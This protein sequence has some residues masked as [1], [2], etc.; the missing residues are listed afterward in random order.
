M[1]LKKLSFM[2]LRFPANGTTGE[3]NNMTVAERKQMAE[4]WVKAGKGK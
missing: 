3:A 4:A 2:V 1:F